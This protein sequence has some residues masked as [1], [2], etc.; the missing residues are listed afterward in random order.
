MLI[1]T[2]RLIDIF[3]EQTVNLLTKPAHIN[4]ITGIAL[5]LFIFCSYLEVYVLLFDIKN[6]RAVYTHVKGGE[7]GPGIKR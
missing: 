5:V 7:N 1:N 6:I 2:H 4:N 3:R